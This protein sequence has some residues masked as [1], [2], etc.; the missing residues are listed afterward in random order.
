MSHENVELATA[1]F[2]AY[3]ARDS[4]A[5]DRLLDPDA[6]ITTLTGSAGMP[7]RWS[8]GTTSEYFEQLD[9]TLADLRVDIQDYRELGERVVALGVI[10][11]AGKASHVEVANDFAVVFVVRSSRI[12]RVDTYNNRRAALEAAGLEE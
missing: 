10:R 7:T 9:E 2:D 5:V 3:N 12:V 8:R 4:D 6:Q 1:F 11:G